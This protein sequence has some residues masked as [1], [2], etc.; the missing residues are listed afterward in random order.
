MSQINLYKIFIF[1]EIFYL[2]YQKLLFVNAQFRHGARSS[3]Y[4][5]DKKNRDIFG[6]FWEK[7]GLLTPKGKLQT[8]LNGVKH[9]E[10]YSSFLNNYYN[11][12]EIKAYS[13]D[14]YRAISSLECYLNGLYHHEEINENIIKDGGVVYP[15]GDTPPIL[16]KKLK[17]LGSNAIPKDNHIIPINIFQKSEHDFVLHEPG[18][19]SDCQVIADTREKNVINHKLNDLSEKFREKYENKLN[20]YF[21]LNNITINSE[22]NYSF[23]QLNLLCDTLYADYIDGK[24]LTNLKQL[25]NFDELYNDCKNI[26]SIIQSDYVSGDKDV[27]IMSQSKPIRKLIKWMDQRIDYD[28]KGLSDKIISGAPRYTIWSGHDSSI[29]TFEMFMKYTFNTKWIFP[30]FA[31]TILFELH[32]IEDKNIYEIKYFVNDE[33]LLTINYD[34]FKNIVKE[35]IWSDERIEQFCHFSIIK[36]EKINSIMK[37]YNR[38]IFVLILLLISS[39]AFNIYNYL[40]TSKK[41]KNN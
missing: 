33:L 10:R 25:I 14:S 17:L 12:D 28:K 41:Q 26:L 20:K 16:E 5:I 35:T 7:R 18:K 31:S 2:T 29:S 6:N 34:D 13:T 19:I 24:N 21:T 1:L 4:I 36:V 3:L 22:F 23:Y 40:K 27:V 32:K 9:R 30:S 37:K 8:F 11:E 15:P 38:I 39:I